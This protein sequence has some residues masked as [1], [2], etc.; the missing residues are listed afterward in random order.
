MGLRGWS[1]GLGWMNG[2]DFARGELL[3]LEGLI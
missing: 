1:G 2:N 3:T